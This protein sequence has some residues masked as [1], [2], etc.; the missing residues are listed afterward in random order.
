MDAISI[1]LLKI[2]R[3]HYQRTFPWHSGLSA[4]STQGPWKRGYNYRFNAFY[5][6]FCYPDSLA[7]QLIAEFLTFPVNQYL[8]LLLTIAPSN[9]NCWW[10]LH[11]SWRSTSVCQILRCPLMFV[12][13]FCYLNAKSKLS[14]MWIE[15]IQLT[16]CWS[17]DCW[18]IASTWF[19]A[20]FCEWYLFLVLFQGHCS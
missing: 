12:P 1:A 7:Y 13:I 15:V 11:W 9:L 16:H 20:T 10:Q 19:Q 17:L 18:P 8:S 2:T 14:S 3:K 6:T 5:L 4:S